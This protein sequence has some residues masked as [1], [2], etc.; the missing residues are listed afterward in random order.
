MKIKSAHIF[1]LILLAFAEFIAD[2]V[3]IPDSRGMEVVVNICGAK[4]TLLGAAAEAG[5]GRQL[6]VHDAEDGGNGPRGISGRGWER[7]SEGGRNLCPPPHGG[8]FNPPHRPKKIR[9]F[10]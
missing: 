2:D 4:E 1:A 3:D 6:Q 7:A 10:G 8:C 9:S 5:I